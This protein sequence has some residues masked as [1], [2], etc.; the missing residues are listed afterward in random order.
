MTH[1]RISVK[2]KSVVLQYKQANQDA[3]T[4]AC[5]VKFH[6]NYTTGTTFAL[7]LVITV[8]LL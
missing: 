6:C 2:D 7:K 5:S 8:V 1:I 4:L 3:S